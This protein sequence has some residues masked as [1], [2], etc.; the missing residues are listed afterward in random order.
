MRVVDLER[1]FRMGKLKHRSVWKHPARTRPWRRWL[2]VVVH[3]FSLNK[4]VA[5]AGKS[6]WIQGQSGLQNEF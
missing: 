6:L 5:E 3:A 4:Q 1:V 2:A